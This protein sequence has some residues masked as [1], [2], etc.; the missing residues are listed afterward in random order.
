MHIHSQSTQSTQRIHSTQSYVVFD[1]AGTIIHTHTV[2]TVE[3]AQERPSAEVER[4]VLE[5]ATRRGF[6][7]ADLGVIRV[8]PEQVEPGV[9]YRV[10]PAARILIKQERTPQDPQLRGFGP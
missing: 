7:E 5:L 8:D 6:E 9:R 2:I 4:R 3:G 1:R 10:D